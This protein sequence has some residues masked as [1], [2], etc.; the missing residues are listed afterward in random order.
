MQKLDHRI[1]D[2]ADPMA[3]ADLIEV[4]T[5]DEEIKVSIHLVFVSLEIRKPEK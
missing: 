3:Q 4:G 2:L 5:E 1:I